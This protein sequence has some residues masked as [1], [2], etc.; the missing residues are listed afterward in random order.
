LLDRYSAYLNDMTDARSRSR[1]LLQNIVQWLRTHLFRTIVLAALTT[2]LIAYFK[3][4]F[5]QIIG[6]TFP[7]GAEVSCI[8]REW[9]VDHWP[10]RPSEA[11]P[12]VF[13]ILVSRLAEDDPDGTQTRAVLRAFQGQKAIDVVSTCRVLK[14][15]AAG[16][17]AEETTATMGREWLARRKA[18]VL[19]FGEVLSKDNV[20]NLLFVSTTPSHDFTPKPFRLETQLLGHDF[21]E[22]AAARLQ[23]VA[24]ASVSPAYEKQGQY[25]VEA[26]R[27]VAGRLQ[28]VIDSPP[29][30]MPPSGVAALQFAS[31]TAL[32][33]IGDQAGDNQAL[34]E[35]ILA[36]RGTLQEWTRS[37]VPFLWAATQNNLGL[38]HLRLGERGSGT[39][40][41]E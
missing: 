5:D 7:K 33:T 41:L 14:I 25:L 20:L 23:A 35:A 30:G 40:H 31:G 10:F 12:G 4:V 29:P 3:G 15:E 34:Q 6:D 11:E 9:T 32:Y 17:T 28:R 39:E 13:R 24:L 36:Y 16:I 1:P 27:P 18:D 38:A 2:S 37:R 8:A 19:V 21:K 26:L 22:A